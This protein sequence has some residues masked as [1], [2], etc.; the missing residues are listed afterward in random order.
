M[1]T[2]GD[3]T[4]YF[5]REGINRKNEKADLDKITRGEYTLHWSQTHNLKYFLYFLH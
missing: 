1:H 2:I 5:A 3:W 4:L